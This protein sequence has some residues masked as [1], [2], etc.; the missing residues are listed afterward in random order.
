MNPT[1]AHELEPL[2]LNIQQQLDNLELR[3]KRYQ[4]KM[5]RQAEKKRQARED[6]RKH[7]HRYHFPVTVLP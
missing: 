5:E 3:H 2:P 1:I 6:H 4:A 7:L